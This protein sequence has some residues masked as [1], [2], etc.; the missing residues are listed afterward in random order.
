MLTLPV[1]KTT[2]APIAGVKITN[3]SNG[4]P[5]NSELDQV[6][7]TNRLPKA[8][9]D[10]DGQT[11]F[12]YERF[13]EGPLF[14]ELSFTLTSPQVVNG[15]LLQAVNIGNSI[16]YTIEDIT[17]NSITG[18]TYSIRDLS[19]PELPDDFFVVKTIGN[20]TFW[21]IVHIPVQCK[22]IVLKLR[23]EN[24]YGTIYKS[25]DGRLIT[26][27]R[28]A[29]AIKAL[30]FKQHKFNQVGGINSLPYSIPAGMY[31]AACRANVYPRNTSLF[32]VNMNVSVDGGENWENDVLGLPEV[33][34]ETLLIDG[35]PFACL[36]NLTLNR[37]DAAFGDATSFNDEEPRVELVSQL[38]TVSDKQSPTTFTLPEKPY[39][40]EVFVMQ[41]KLARRT[42]IPSEA[43]LLDVMGSA[44]YKII[45][46]PF[47]LADTNLTDEDA[48]VYFEDMMCWKA[49]L[50]PGLEEALETSDDIELAE[51]W[52]NFIGESSGGDSES[53]GTWPDYTGLEAGDTVVIDTSDEGIG[54]DT[55]TA[56]IDDRN[57]DDFQVTI[58]PNTW[59]TEGTWLAHH[60]LSYGHGNAYDVTNI[61]LNPNAINAL[62]NAFLVEQSPG[63]WRLHVIFNREMDLAEATNPNNYTLKITGGGNIGLTSAGGPW[64]YAREDGSGSNSYDYEFQLG[65]NPSATNYHEVEITATIHVNGSAM[66][67]RISS[68]GGAQPTFY[69]DDS[70]R[71]AGCCEAE[72]SNGSSDEAPLALRLLGSW[73]LL[74]DQA[75]IN[76]MAP[77]G[78]S[79]S[80]PAVGDEDNAMAGFD[81]FNGRISF[82]F[83]EEHLQF[84]ER[85]DG[86]YC[87]LAM[88][89]DP[90]KENIAIKHLPQGASKIT[91][92]LPMG[93]KRYDLGYKYITST[94]SSLAF[95][96][97][98][99]EATPVEALSYTSLISD[100]DGT[101]DYYFDKQNGIV[102]FS[103]PLNLQCIATIYH[104]TPTTLKNSDYEI[105]TDGPRPVGVIVKPNAMVTTTVSERLDNE[106][107]L[108]KVFDVETGEHSRR[109]HLFGEDEM[110][111]FTLS[112]K[113]IVKGSVSI[114]PAVFGL[115]EDHAPP[116]EMPFKDGST[117]FY[118]LIP[119]NNE[120]TPNIEADSEGWVQFKLAAGITWNKAAG[121]TYTDNEG[122][123]NTSNVQTYF[124]SIDYEDI[125]SDG[126]TLKEEARD[127][128]NFA[129]QWA[130]NGN[131]TIG[132]GDPTWAIDDD[133]TVT[134]Y[135][136]VGGELPAG[137][138]LNYS[139]A[140]PTFDSRNRFSVDYKEGYIYLSQDAIEHD[141]EVVTYKVASYNAA[142]NI[143]KEINTYNYNPNTNA[144]SIRTENITKEAGNQI[145]ILWGKPPEEVNLELFRE[146]FSP[147][148][149]NT[150]IRF[151]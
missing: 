135:V 118:G 95:N 25:T 76:V 98:A 53:G 74:S 43:Q 10:G 32:D 114:K 26:R 105:W 46:L 96:I 15:I 101:Y 126:N 92:Q 24:S 67:N 41:P 138:Q 100:L 6:V 31:A 23:Q 49:D 84:I 132:G 103:E 28:Y 113:N 80:K 127:N 37:A 2:T 145:K 59:W 65:S 136:G 122:N 133:G 22:S 70:W 142:Y 125:V 119:I 38:N 54:Q 110:R 17:F 40:K 86:Y 150:G 3:K 35:N 73:Q 143:A 57:F 115:P 19:T 4:I 52:E 63:I 45:N 124:G 146:Y 104:A 144:V 27:E 109:D 62:Y 99:D 148:V 71:T 82:S 78:T 20:D 90:D 36:W 120:L 61:D 50:R 11:W 121:I 12:E 139:Y 64:V 69:R 8:I 33:E 68:Q 131:A 112:H 147:I 129:T 56:T 60:M 75:R 1:Q 51:F 97:G 7:V 116:I 91:M 93:Q 16:N 9:F 130:S 72:D 111:Y 85:S 117:E 14:L 83:K 77:W 58:A 94:T 134:V 42:N 44:A 123:T 79:F 87:R 5:G 13:D 39:N 18:K 137:I 66:Y 21:E 30:E 108:L 140:D 141:E 149:Y 128:P 107:T 102:H 55:L 106:R 89:F 47:P 29:I 88:L 151:Q 48:R 34:G 81:S